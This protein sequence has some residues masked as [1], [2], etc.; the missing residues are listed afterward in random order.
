MID[1][2]ERSIFIADVKN[3]FDNKVNTSVFEKYANFK[4]KDKALKESVN[5]FL[6]DL[7]EECEDN[8]NIEFDD[9]RFEEKSENDW[10]SIY[11]REVNFSNEFI[12]WSNRMLLL[13]ESE[14]EVIATISDKKTSKQAYFGAI[15]FLCFFTI[16]IFALKNM[17]VGIVLFLIL[18]SLTSWL[19]L[20]YFNTA[21]LQVE[22]FNNLQEISLARRSMQFFEKIQINEQRYNCNEDIQKKKTFGCIIL[23]IIGYLIIIA[24]I[25]L[26]I[27][28]I[29]PS[30]K[31]NILKT[32]IKN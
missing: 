16:F 21:S 1:K 30:N 28:S 6:M 3:F 26:L 2:M 23:H 17:I 9:G 27:I 29:E 19:F 14:T 25:P 18:N 8:F 24:L 7:C 32:P 22:P 5:V 31:K 13:L 15:Y 11:A 12:K 10:V 20:K 4:S